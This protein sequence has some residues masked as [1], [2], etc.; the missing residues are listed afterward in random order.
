MRDT[1]HGE[2]ADGIASSGEWGCECRTTSETA[3][4]TLIA[5]ASS[6]D[7]QRVRL[8]CGPTAKQ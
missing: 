1:T 6:G 2:T 7:A 5:A 8:G 4:A 3:E